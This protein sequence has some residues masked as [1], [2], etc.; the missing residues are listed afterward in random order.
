ML[1]HAVLLL[2]LFCA[3]SICSTSSDLSPVEIQKHSR[4]PQPVTG[5]SPL[6][7]FERKGVYDVGQRCLREGLSR[8]G[9]DPDVA[10]AGSERLAARDKHIPVLGRAL[11]DEVVGEQ[12]FCPD[13]V[14]ADCVGEVRRRH[15]R[16]HGRGGFFLARG[17]GEDS[18][19]S[20][21]DMVGVGKY[22]A[23]RAGGHKPRRMVQ[24]LSALPEGEV[25]ADFH[26]VDDRR[27]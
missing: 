11:S 26:L 14:C 8:R 20:D 10:Y 22:V 23:A 25:Q 18:K 4:K 24:N 19:G 15:C 21:F 2:S 1:Y 3:Q 17:N 5:F 7:R 9:T 13:A 16:H 27:R 12:T 6:E